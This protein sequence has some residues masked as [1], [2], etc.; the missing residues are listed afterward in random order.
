MILQPRLIPS[1]HLMERKIQKPSFYSLHGY[2]ENGSPTYLSSG[3]PLVDF[4]FHVVPYTPSDS[5]MKRLELAW[6][7]DPLKALKLICNLRGLHKHH[8]KTLAANV[9]SFAEFGYFK[10]LP[11]ILQRITEEGQEKEEME[12][13]I[14]KRKMCCTFKTWKKELDFIQK[15]PQEDRIQ[16]DIKRGQ[17]VKE[18]MSMLREER[19]IKKAVRV[20]N[21]Y[22][23]DE[24]YRLLHDKISEVFAEYLVA[25]LK[26]LNEGPSYGISFAAKWYPSL[27]LCY[28]Q[29]TL[30]CESIARRIFTRES[31]PEYENVDE[32]HYAYRIR[33][34]LR[35]EVL[36]PLHKASELPE[37][38]MSANKWELLP[39]NRVPSVAMNNYK[40]V[41]M[42]HDKERFTNH[43]EGVK[44]GDEKHKIAAGALLP[45]LI[46]KSLK[47]E[48]ES[49]CNVP[50]LQ[51]R[52][53]LED[54]SKIGKLKDCLAI[55]DV[56]ESM[57]GTPMD[58][59]VALGL[60]ISE[61]SHEPWKG[62]L[63][64]FSLD[65][66]LHK[67]EGDTLRSKTEFIRRMKWGMTTNFQ[68]V[69]DQILQVAVEGNLKED[70]MIK[71]LFVFSDMEFNQAKVKGKY[72]P[73]DYYDRQSA[74]A[75]WET[76]YQVIQNKFREKGYRNVPEIVFWNLR[77]SHSTPVLSQQKG[78]AMVSGL[79]K[80]MIK[81][82]L[83]DPDFSEF[84]P[85]SVMEKAISG[86]EY[87]K[88]VVV[89]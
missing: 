32:A 84:T 59:S 73:Y 10:D 80:N 6:E 44:R 50:E 23:G 63:I 12:I 66:E 9:K 38:Y 4:Y 16:E 14:T 87:N 71:R 18:K 33:D 47:I 64:T 58:V 15:I 42:N 53:M 48:E 68:K 41:F 34:R 61:M 17:L 3:N 83:E 57:R 2:T 39:Y 11:E 46:I 72:S 28:D 35:K 37:L 85:S 43:L 86:E 51:W 5:V 13:C 67:I 52:R 1:F 88:L 27:Y 19:R 70:Q 26:I 8:P 24:N 29:S 77:E 74:D 30:L 22:N 62:K 20:I 60:L 79:S 31:Y 21:R 7:Y 75:E 40:E 82:F 45:H 78:V 55:S 25:D 54:L 81:V 69:F 89:D 76:D 49:D 36:V 65:P 56:S